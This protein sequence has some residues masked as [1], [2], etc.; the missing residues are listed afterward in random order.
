MP[1]FENIPFLLFSLGIGL[2]LITFAIK[3][4][5]KLL[6]LSIALF[7]ASLEISWKSKNLSLIIPTEPLY[8]V[9]LLFFLFYIVF[10]FK[11]I[12]KNKYFNHQLFIV[13]AIH[14]IWI[15]VTA[16]V[17]EMLTV[18]L[19]FWIVRCWYVIPTV[20]LFYL[21]FKDSF[22]S[23]L[24]RVWLIALTT[25]TIVIVITLIRHYYYYF[26]AKVAHWIA[27]PFFRDH[28]SYAATIAFLL[29]FVVY[30]ILSSKKILYKIL[31]TGM[32]LLFLAGLVLSY[33]R[34]AWLSVFFALFVCFF[35]LIKLSF[36]KFLLIILGAGTLTAS[37]MN[38]FEELFLSHKGT[39]V[40]E[41]P[42]IKRLKMITDL[43]YDASNLERINR[44]ICSYRM[45]TERPLTGW[46][47]GSY[48]FLYDY[49]QTSDY[50]TS[51][52]THYGDVGN[53][54]SDFFGSLAE[55][56]FPGALLWLLINILTFYYA[57]KSFPLL[58]NKNEKLLLA[59]SF[60]AYSSYFFHSNLNNFL[61]IDK[62][63]IPFFLSIATIIYFSSKVCKA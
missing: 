55:Q 22:E 5:K 59:S 48:M 58:K 23:S 44:W 4:F 47:P 39:L 9:F 29:F 27:Q 36:A 61:D 63:A 10:C 49:W 3:N 6:L 57:F 14:L 18:S 33:T 42:L 28:T 8:A 1:L 40:A 43:R 7:P 31:F 20:I 2:I 25:M 35:L 38:Y 60:A 16:L 26:D 34:A 11:D 19:K 54:H 13:V 15:L 37:F 50:M 62:I 51:I 46:G 52:S 30:F 17:S 45:F 12:K 53:A 21:F 24:E 41:N 32:L 56:G